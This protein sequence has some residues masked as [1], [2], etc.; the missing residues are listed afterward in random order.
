MSAACV[1]AA[2]GYAQEQAVVVAAG[3]PLHVHI[4]KS[5]DMRVGAPVEGVLTQQVWVYDRLALPLGARVRGRVAALEP[6]PHDEHVK[7][8]LN[9]DV[10]PLRQAV[11][12][13]DRVRVGE[14]DVPL[15]SEG[16]MR[17]VTKVR[18]APGEKK[19][20]LFETLKGSARDKVDSTKAELFGPGKKD[21]ALHLLYNQLPYHPQ[22]IWRDEDYVADLTEPARVEVPARRAHIEQV[23]EVRDSSIA[24]S[25]PPD[26]EVRGRLVT[27]ID[28]DTAKRGDPVTAIVTRPVYDADQKLVL[29]EGTELDGLVEKVKRSRSFGRNGTLNFRFRTVRRPGQEAQT[30]RGTLTGAEGNKD[31]NVAVDAEGNV[32]AQPAKNRFAAPLLLAV[33]AAIGHDD[34]GGAGQ[35]VVG[36]NGLGLVARVVTAA[37]GS[38]NVAGAFGAY[39]L[40]KSVYFRSLTRGHPV[41]FLK[42]TPVEV[43]LSKR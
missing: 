32:K 25:L 1:A 22:R 31:Q 13:F 5:A 26:A 14:T 30:M 4:T 34:D 35:Q 39:G 41:T 17:P 28:S 36:A 11:V 24:G 19:P 3:V 18:F 38:A 29:P 37:S 20:S 42:D 7:A 40:A 6:V 43:Q 10:T 8:L 9:G 15:E 27:P 2:P 16:R 23:V 21:R 33:T 12:D